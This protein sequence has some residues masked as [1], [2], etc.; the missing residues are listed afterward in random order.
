MS[1]AGA[2]SAF[3][4]QAEALAPLHGYVSGLLAPVPLLRVAALDVFGA[5]R[6]SMGAF[7]AGNA[8]PGQASILQE[9]VAILVIV[10]GGETF[11]G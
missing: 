6:L 7:W 8:A 9:V 2:L 10:F 1:K 3:V 11:L 5:A 4:A